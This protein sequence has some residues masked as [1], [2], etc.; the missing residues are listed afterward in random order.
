[1]EYSIRAYVDELFSDIPE[2]QR[3][4]E[5][6]V[7]LTQNLL[8]KYN[9]LVASG[10]S[11]E[12]AYNITVYGIGDI[13]ELLDELKREEVRA[14]IGRTES[15]YF[16][17]MAYY[18]RHSAKLITLGVM[19]CVFSLIPVIALPMIGRMLDLR[20]FGG[21]GVA[22]MFL[23]LGFAVGLFVWSGITK[24]KRSDPPE[25]VVELYE[26]RKNKA[27]SYIKVFDASY[28]TVLVAAYLLLSFLTGRWDITWIMFVAGPAVSAVVHAMAK[29]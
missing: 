26:R 19:F 27:V 5:M 20:G 8:D 7:E 23:F 10:K 11:E 9:D 28:W 3:A 18:K 13:S 21:I 12:D 1:M 16:E 17:A 6:K 25:M 15:A 14:N 4:Y 22:V 24:P 29:K 2:S